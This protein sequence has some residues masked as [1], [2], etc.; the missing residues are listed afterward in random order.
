MQFTGR[1]KA[2]SSIVAVLW[3]S[4]KADYRSGRKL[5]PVRPLVKKWSLLNDMR[6]STVF[7]KANLQT[8]QLINLTENFVDDI[9]HRMERSPTK[10][11]PQLSAQTGLLIGSCHKALMELLHMH[12]YKVSI[13][14]ELHPP[15][16]NQCIQYCHGLMKINNNVL[17]LTC[18]SDEAWVHLSGYVNW[19]TIKLSKLG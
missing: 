11:V 16:Y 12:S 2:C 5:S 1:R 17:D 7:A 15:D 6:K 4:K 13:V 8:G 9:R 3:V 14:Q 18:F 10:S 19:A